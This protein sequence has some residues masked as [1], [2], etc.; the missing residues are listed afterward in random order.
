[1]KK[2]TVHIALL[3]ALT[4]G[5]LSC[6]HQPEPANTTADLD[7]PGAR[8]SNIVRLPNMW[9]L[10][11]VGRQIALGDFPVNIAVHPD[12]KFA[13]VLH[14][15]HG[16]HEIVVVEI[17]SG[18]LVSH[19]ALE[20]SFYGLA[21]S[22]DGKTLFCSGA[23]D[24]TV[25]SFA[26]AKGFLNDQ[27]TVQLRDK[28][29]RGI[30]GGL[31]VTKDADRLFVANVWG[32]RVTEVNLTSQS[33]GN[34][35]VLGT[36]KMIA[37]EAQK[38]STEDEDAIKKR[39]ETALEASTSLD[40]FPYTC[41]LDEKRDRLYVSLWAQA[42]VA[43]IN[44]KDNEIIAR[45]KTEEHPNEMLL[46]KSG[47]YLFVANANRNT[48]SILD[49]DTGRTKETLLAELVP[50]SPPGSTPNSLALSPDEKLLFVANANINAIS[51]FDIA[52]HGKSRS[53]GFIPVGW[54]P[55]SVRVTP[56]GKH[57]LVT[58]GKGLI[59]K[60]NRNGP[61]VTREP[62]ASVREYIGGLFRGTLS[63]IDLP[64]RDRLEDQMKRY[65]AQAYSCL[66][67]TNTITGADVTRLPIKYCIYIIKENRT[68]DQVFGDMPK[69][70]GDPSLCL[71]N[72]R[73]TPNH[74]KLAS[75][76]VLLDNFYVESE[77]SAD[78]HEWT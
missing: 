18:R 23:G 61:Q 37:F 76:F 14:S 22:Q 73:I 34:E 30:P 16:Q 33:V 56:D 59:S 78:G 77:V 64:G 29:L 58:N 66:P 57:L 62:P 51:V 15:G 26:F 71:F 39:A 47:K 48:V 5:L 2:K 35:I 50:N 7:I 43:V 72:E 53:L 42:A 10:R 55:T 4:L 9:W 69:G 49:T 17:S 65:T 6:A 46:S 60:A 52:E 25:H 36:N 67:R 45:W 24:E 63:I 19:A 75:E 8:G 44:L 31:A 13:A 40:P 11:P 32:H 1:M 54:Y 70:N 28:K 20:E 3:V 27:K 41:L 68:Y 38:P 12:G 74:H 21:F